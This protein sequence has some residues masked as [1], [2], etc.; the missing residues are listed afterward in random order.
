VSALLL[1]GGGDHAKVVLDVARAAGF[2]VAGF[3]D[4]DPAATLIGDVRRLGGD[5]AAPALRA[6]GLALAFVALGDNRLRRKIG[7]RLRAQGFELATL[8]H[9][10][11]VVS[12]SAAIGLGTVVMPLAV[13]NAA[14]RI[15]GHVIVNTGAIVEHDCVLGEGVHVAPRS[16][17][18]GGC[19]LGEEVFFGIGACARPL[20]RIGAGATV[21][22]GAV[23]VREIMAGAVVAGV[24]ARPLTRACAGAAP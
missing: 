2:S 23:V 17:L 15:G 10:S 3:L 13:I 16:A 6:Q 20:S 1:V 7:E 19:T 21:G 14:A 8:A 5:E 11:A 4:P 22:A 12:P 24:P 18:G 9:P